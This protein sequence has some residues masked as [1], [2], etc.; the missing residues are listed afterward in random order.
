M[1]PNQ[2]GQVFQRRHGGNS[3]RHRMPSQPVSCLY[4]LTG[5]VH[6]TWD[7]YQINLNTL[8]QLF[9]A[10]V[11]IVSDSPG[12][13]GHVVAGICADL[14]GLIAL[15]RRPHQRFLYGQQFRNIDGAAVNLSFHQEHCRSNLSSLRGCWPARRSGPA[16]YRNTIWIRSEAQRSY[17]HPSRT[18]CFFHLHFNC[19]RHHVPFHAASVLER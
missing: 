14:D 12:D 2:T 18:R 15:L 9:D 6:R 10:I 4:V 5:R 16:S 19:V 8:A 13:P 11:E 3:P 17:P 7:P 1:P